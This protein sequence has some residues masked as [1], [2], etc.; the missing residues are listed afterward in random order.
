MTDFYK[1]IKGD[2]EELKKLMLL[3]EKN[4]NSSSLKIFIFK[5]LMEDSTFNKS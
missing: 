5:Q 2:E 4:F 3:D 1:L